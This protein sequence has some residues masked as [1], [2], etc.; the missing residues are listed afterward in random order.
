[1]KPLRHAIDRLLGW[2]ICFLMGAMVL[3]VLWQVFTRF[4]LR[5]PSSFTEEAARYM[6]IWVGLLGS[7]YAAGRKSHLA[8]DLVTAHLHGSRKRAS[9]LFIHAAVLVFALAVLVGGG[10]RLV[11]IQLSLGQQ[12]A[13]LQLK[14]G[15]VYLAVPL[16]G[17][18]I[19]FYSLLAFLD[20]LRGETRDG[21]QSSGLN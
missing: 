12:S 2:V 10:G 13:A 17:A 19:A 1:M 3:N 18:F 8:L 7:A 9:E 16:A 11:W 5:T 21:Q 4:V 6:M 15:Y 14:L 20:A